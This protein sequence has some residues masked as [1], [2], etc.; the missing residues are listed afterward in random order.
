[1]GG[2]LDFI[3]QAA[4]LCVEDEKA[5]GEQRKLLPFRRPYGRW[6]RLNNP[7]GACLFRLKLHRPT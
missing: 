5:E 4:A 3:F 6:P 2:G 7:E 1:V